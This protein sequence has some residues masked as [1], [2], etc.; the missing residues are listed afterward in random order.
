MTA[1]GQAP[2]IDVTGP[3]F[4]FGRSDVHAA[5]ELGW[6]ART[7]IG[8]MVLRYAEATDILADRRLSPTGAGHLALHGIDSGPIHDYFS[9][10]LSSRARND[11]VRLRAVLAPYLGS[12][13]LA[14]LR[15]FATARARELAEGLAGEAEVMSDFAGPLAFAVCCELLGL[16]PEDADRFAAASAEVG[17]V[18]SLSMDGLRPLVEAHL[19]TLSDY[20]DDLLARRLREP[21]ADFVSA[22]AAAMAA[23]GISRAQCRSVLTSLVMGGHDAPMHQVGCAVAALAEHPEQ[24][25]LLGGEPRL[26]DRATEEILRWTAHTHTMRFAVADFEYAGLAVPIGGP[27]L[28][29]NTAANRDPRAFAR[30]EVFD[31][32]AERRRPPIAFGGGPY[33]CPGSALGRMLIAV[34]VTALTGRFTPPSAAGPSRWRPRTTTAYGPDH[35]PLIFAA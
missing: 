20:F 1:V 25:A 12:R 33:F 2:H 13:R 8:P 7:P 4:H 28:T 15:A 31:I 6:H 14:C 29:A 23:E 3:G 21:G 5:R 24:W 35:L 26:A 11:H 17:L 30:P 18:F 10:N 34:A 32:A 9:V 22:L 19:A 16:P 27:V